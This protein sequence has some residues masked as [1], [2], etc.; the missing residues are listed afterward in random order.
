[1]AGLHVDRWIYCAWQSGLRAAISLVFS[2]YFDL[3]QIKLIMG[4]VGGLVGVAR[5]V[6]CFLVWWHF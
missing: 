4:N 5:Y 6:G 1:M 3:Y 2:M